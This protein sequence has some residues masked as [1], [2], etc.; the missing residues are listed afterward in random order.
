MQTDKCLGFYVLEDHHMA[1]IFYLSFGKHGALSLFFTFD[2]SS[3]DNI[4][5]LQFCELS[6]DTG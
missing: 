6:V 3:I 2:T 5:A 1:A 4:V